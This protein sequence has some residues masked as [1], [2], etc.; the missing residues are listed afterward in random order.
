MVL[1]TNFIDNG[2]TR[3]EESPLKFREPEWTTEKFVKSPQEKLIILPRVESRTVEIEDDERLDDGETQR[4]EDSETPRDVASSTI[5]PAADLIRQQEKYDEGVAREKQWHG[6]VQTM[7]VESQDHWCGINVAQVVDTT[8]N[9]ILGMIGLDSAAGEKE[10]AKEHQ[11]LSIEEVGLTKE[12]AGL[13]EAVTV[14]DSPSVIAVITR[15]PNKSKKIFKNIR[16]VFLG[17]K[18]VDATNVNDTEHIIELEKEIPM[19][20]TVKDSNG[21]IMEESTGIVNVAETQDTPPSSKEKGFPVKQPVEE[22]KLKDDEQVTKEAQIPAAEAETTIL[23]GRF[24]FNW[25]GIY[26]DALADNVPK[27]ELKLIDDEHVRKETT[28]NDTAEEETAEVT[29]DKTAEVT[30]D[31]HA[32][33]A[34]DC[35]QVESL[36]GNVLTLRPH[37]WRKRVVHNIRDFCEE[38]DNKTIR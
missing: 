5:L 36:A 1:N 29:D 28:R 32:A 15:K 6:V 9:E 34:K 14:D 11:V 19:E 31:E 16:R 2:Y 21:G 18:K 4:L 35:F 3:G 27:N 13:E 10:T 33:V 30:E 12:K 26:K 25:C 24:M 37:C 8:F 20:R 7:D 22:L 38:K 17:R 23:D